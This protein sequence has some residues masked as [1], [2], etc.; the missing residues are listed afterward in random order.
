M[1]ECPACA[2]PRNS[3]HDLCCGCEIVLDDYFVS[4]EGHASK[5]PPKMSHVTTEGNIGF[6][7]EEPMPKVEC[8]AA[9]LIH[10]AAGTEWEV[11]CYLARRIQEDAILFPA[12]GCI[13]Y[14][15][16]LLWRNAKDKG[17]A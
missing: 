10:K 4:C 11:N 13:D 7:S 12:E 17:N 14:T 1:P 16:C 9:E 2:G 15:Q 6:T 8:P 3:Y 5:W